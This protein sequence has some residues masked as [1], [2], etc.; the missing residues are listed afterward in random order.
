MVFKVIYILHTKKVAAMIEHSKKH[1]CLCLGI[2]FADVVCQ[3][4][5]HLPAPGELVPTERVELS[6]GG[7]ALCF[8]RR[9]G[10]HNEL[11]GIATIVTW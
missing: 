9:I 7:R 8:G 5:S 11:V 4:I 1:D 3:P 10:K 6:L 2:L